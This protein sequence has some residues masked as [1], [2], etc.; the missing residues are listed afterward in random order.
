MRSLET[1]INETT[2]YFQ[3]NKFNQKV[4][5]WKQDIN[6]GPRVAAG[7]ARLGGSRT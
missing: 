5:Y 2:I 1:C 7:S 6:S 4:G 3:L